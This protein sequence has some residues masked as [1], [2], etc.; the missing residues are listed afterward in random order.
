MTQKNVRTRTLRKYISDG[1]IKLSEADRDFLRDLSRVHIIDEKDA[2]NTHYQ[3]R[4][5]PASRRLDRLCEAGILEKV[6]VGQPGRGRFNAYT[7]STSKVATLFK[8]KRIVTTGRRNAL[9]EVITSRLYFAVGRPE[10][11]K[12]ESNFNDEEKKVF[13][14]ASPS[15]T[16]RMSSIPDALYYDSSNNM[17]VVEADSGQY[18]KRQITSKQNAWKDFKQ[19]W[20]QPERASSRINNA[21]VFRFS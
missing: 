7:F 13:K 11:F 2:D 10:S 8:G 14:L 15:I 18:N 4:K 19:V 12:V 1:S 16:E 20:G 6:K 17:V 21:E 3:D 9:H 5:T